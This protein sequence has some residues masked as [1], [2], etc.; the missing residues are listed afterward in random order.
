MINSFIPIW[1]YHGMRGNSIFRILAAHPEVY[2]DKYAH[3]GSKL[4]HP[5]YVPSNI[6]SI[7]SLADN[8]IADKIGMWKMA[9]ATYHTISSIRSPAFPTIIRN[10]ALD[11]SKH[12]SLLFCYVN[13]VGDFN[14]VKNHK[15]FS[16]NKPHIQVYGKLD[17]LG[18]E[19]IE[20]KPSNNPQAYNLNIDNLFSTDYITFETEYYSLI[21]H[22]NLT[23]C[24]NDVRAF[25]LLVLEREQYISKFY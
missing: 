6:T 1:S 5:L 11:F 18:M 3:A 17:R 12:R 10:W 21:A 24:L 19:V 23:S 14:F 2:W 4:L 13:P 22:F 9:Y 15:L 7:E 8:D 20:Y 25:I 16:M